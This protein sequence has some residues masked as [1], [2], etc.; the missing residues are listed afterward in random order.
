MNVHR[1]ITPALSAAALIVAL[2]PASA[3]SFAA[4]TSDCTGSLAVT[5]DNPNAGD[6]LSAGKYT[7]Q[8]SAVDYAAASGSGIDRVMVSLDD[9][10]RGG[11]P[12]GQ[13]TLG[14]A[15]PT[16]F[17]ATVDLTNFSGAHTVEV[18]A[19]SSVS[20]NEAVVWA[21]INI[22]GS[23]TS[24]PM[25]GEPPLKACAQPLAGA[26]LVV[27]PAPAAAPAIDQGHFGFGND[28]SIPGYTPS[29]SINWG[30]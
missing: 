10:D 24:G 22:G 14:M 28:T 19:H 21:P 25:L 2:L 8:G 26:P 3:P 23:N 12:L 16:S 30:D 27:N 7:L 6:V 13:A 11:I 17:V 18:R 29:Q 15:S 4:S 9:R 20:G 1:F 5:L